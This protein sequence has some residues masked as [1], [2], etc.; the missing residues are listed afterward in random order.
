MEK[1]GKH[2][3]HGGKLCKKK[4]IDHEDPTP[5][6]DQVYLG[7]TQREAKAD[8]QALQS[9]TELF[10][11]LTTTRLTKKNQTKE[12]LFIGKD[13]CLEL[14]YGRSCRKDALG[15]TAD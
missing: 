9:K 10:K 12:I 3:F 6:I 4:S 1:K 11:K 8:P 15:D 14:L 13:Q 7:C 5:W 2:G